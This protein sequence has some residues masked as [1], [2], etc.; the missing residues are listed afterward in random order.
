MP[1][2]TPV[3]ATS[4]TRERERDTSPKK[5]AFTTAYV[6]AGSNQDGALGSRQAY[7]DAARS[8]L[9][10]APGVHVQRVSPVIETAPVGGPAGQGPFLNAVFELE[11]TLSARAML[12]LLLDVERA[13]GRERR[14]KWGPRTIDLDLLI[15]GDA[16][17]H[18]AGLDVPHPE[19]HRRRFVLEPL[20]ALAPGLTHPVLGKTVAQLLA[21]L[22]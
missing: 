22:R 5:R 10:N 2:G 19:A 12:T 14:E 20:A 6:G 9:D 17:L 3:P 7:L 4:G 1:K 15:H 18:E 11:T 8:A 13:L 21:E 16:V